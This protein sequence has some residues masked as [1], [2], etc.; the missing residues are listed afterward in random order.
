MHSCAETSGRLVS[1][2]IP[3]YNAAHFLVRA[4]QSVIDQTYQNWEA[5]VIDNHSS[6]NTDEVVFGFRNSRIRL[7]KVRNEGV[8]A[9]SRNLGIRESI[10]HWVAFLD[11]DDWWRPD[12]LQLSVNALS[13]GADIVYHDLLRTGPQPLNLFARRV[14]RSR[15]LLPPVYDDLVNFGNA[16]LNS[17][18][19]VCRELLL[20]VG[21]LSENP[22]LVAAED[23]ECWLRVA[24][25]TDR[26]YRI[27]G[28][29]GYYW[30][31]NTNTSSSG[32]TIICLSE[33][34]DH[35]L[36][37][38]EPGVELYSPPWL[39][40]ALAKANYEVSDY[41]AC[42]AELKKLWEI[43]HAIGWVRVK[44]VLLGVLLLGKQWKHSKA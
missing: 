24:R 7:L 35:Y 28:A 43:K 30:I 27:P 20:N 16:L 5:L 39:S 22:R 13:E 1:I 18:V 6:D 11:A 40:F 37:L 44:A 32:R 14:I 3:T 2:V 29:H 41:D 19:V 42:Q 31:G 36:M 21:G 33:L 25:L 38:G 15:K 26:F 10:G 12:K 34:R 17:S 9:V 23:F 4:L 8:I